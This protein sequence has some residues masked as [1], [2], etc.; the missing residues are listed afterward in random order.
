VSPTSQTTL[1]MSARLVRD[2]C[3]KYK[4]PMEFVDAPGLVALKRGITTHAEV[5]K[6]F[7]GGDHWDPGP[8]FPVDAYMDFIKTA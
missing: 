8:G 7:K 3:D 5:T 4:I 6:A 1:Q 2:L